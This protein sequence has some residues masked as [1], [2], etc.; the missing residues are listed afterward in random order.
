MKICYIQES[1][2]KFT[3]GDNKPPNHHVRLVTPCKYTLDATCE[4]DISLRLWHGETLACEIKK[5]RRMKNEL[6]DTRTEV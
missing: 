3:T 4:M 6:A 2:S 5:V 1:C